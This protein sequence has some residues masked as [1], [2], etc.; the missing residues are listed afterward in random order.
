MNK[1]NQVIQI[2]LVIGDNINNNNNS[3]MGEKE[4][5]INC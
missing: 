1:K 3:K 5:I 2:Q 4:T